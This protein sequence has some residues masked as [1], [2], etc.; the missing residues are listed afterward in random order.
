MAGS[1]AKRPALFRQSHYLAD[2]Q[3]ALTAVR[4]TTPNTGRTGGAA[5]KPAH[6]GATS[7]PGSTPYR[8]IALVSHRMTLP[9]Q[10][11]ML[12]FHGSAARS[13]RVRCPV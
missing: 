2:L 3:T 8:I 9:Y 12:A 13:G 6:A 4:P 1:G 10:Q 5:S 11:W 7:A